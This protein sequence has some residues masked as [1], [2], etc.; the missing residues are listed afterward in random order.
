MATM[1]CPPTRRMASSARFLVM[2]LKEAKCDHFNTDSDDED[3]PRTLAAISNSGSESGDD[4]EHDSDD[5]SGD[6]SFSGL[7]YKE[8]CGQVK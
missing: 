7:I 6:E 8:G 5:D 4:D 3:E 1:D 2:V